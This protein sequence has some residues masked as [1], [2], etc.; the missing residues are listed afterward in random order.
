VNRNSRII[1]LIVAL[2]FFLL[3]NI[4]SNTIKESYVLENQKK[5]SNAL[6]LMIKLA[7]KNPRHY[8][9]NLRA[10][11][12]AYLN[13]NLSESVYYYRK[14]VVLAPNAIEPRLG[15]M[16]PLTVLGKF[17]QVIT[18][19]NA[20]LRK[21]NRN[22]SARS[23]IAYALYLAGNVKLAEKY[24]QSLIQDYPSDAEMFIGLGWALIRQ[25]KK[26]AA[27]RYFYKA[28]VIYPD[29]KRVAAGLKACKK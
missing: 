7:N 4:F 25:G 29:N 16:L 10:G 26:K 11:W 18:V 23:R 13:G 22:Y 6:V 20:I 14:A 21:D 12:L 3:S 15:L 9:A 27:C 8:L 19:G 1:K 2:L 17:S 24:Y 28:D 5:Y